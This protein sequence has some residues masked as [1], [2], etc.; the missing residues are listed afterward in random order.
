MRSR[1]GEPGLN[2]HTV[3]RKRPDEPGSNA[4]RRQRI[5]G[6]LHSIVLPA[7]RDRFVSPGPGGVLVR[8]GTMLDESPADYLGSHAFKHALLTG[9]VETARAMVASALGSGADPARMI[10]DDFTAAANEMGAD[11]VSDDASFSEV[12]VGMVALHVLLRDLETELQG[13]LEQVGSRR[14]VVTCAVPPNQHVF[15]A[16]ILETFL[17]CSGYAVASGHHS[18]RSVLLGVAADQ[19]VEVAGISM[20]DRQNLDLCKDFIVDLRAASRNDDLKIIVGGRP[21]L[22]DETLVGYVGGDA[23][24]PDALL[25]LQKIEAL[26]GGDGRE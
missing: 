17:R 23:T 6:L 20:L 24:A 18:D 1:F 5:E 3:P 7:L 19:H 14:M 10:I 16:A 8:G 11:W 25:A 13:S 26:V 4:A 22:E 15:G 9:D 12:S 21:F 2:V